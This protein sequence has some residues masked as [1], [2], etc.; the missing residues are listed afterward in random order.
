MYVDG[1]HEWWK[2]KVYSELAEFLKH[3][4]PT[5]KRQLDMTLIT[6][7]E[8]FNHSA[9]TDGNCFSEMELTMNDQ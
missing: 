4:S 7:E 9:R 3:P 6:Y 5:R 2:I 1:G 8:L